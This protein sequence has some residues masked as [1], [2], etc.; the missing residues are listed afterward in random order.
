MKRRHK[1]AGRVPSSHGGNRMNKR[2][3]EGMQTT[4][5]VFALVG[6]WA[7]LDW[8]ITPDPQPDLLMVELARAR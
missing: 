7:V 3:S 8:S 6:A 2:I 5:L 1:P 4:L